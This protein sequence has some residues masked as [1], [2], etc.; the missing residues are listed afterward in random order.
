MTHIHKLLLAAA[1]IGIFAFALK[2]RLD[3][4]G[5]LHYYRGE[6]AQAVAG[7]VERANDGEPTAAMLLGNIYS[8]G[9]GL[10][11]NFA[12][13]SD[14]YSK[15]TQMGDIKGVRHVVQN[16]FREHP[17]NL[18]DARGQRCQTATDLLDMAAR[19]GDIGAKIDLGRYYESGY[20]V[21]RNLATAAKHF[22]AVSRLDRRFSFLFENIRQNLTENESADFE[23]MTS[24]S[25]K[26]KPS[27]S[28]VIDNMVR[29]LP[30]LRAQK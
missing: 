27:V 9:M 4:A 5:Y 7:L 29:S 10:E 19:A 16:A 18:N 2:I 30:V 22:Q 15:Q 25:V 28:D 26:S 21:E 11:R 12:A 8:H 23:N 6:P 14:W 17:I 1:I 3:E 13:A 24:T 20:C